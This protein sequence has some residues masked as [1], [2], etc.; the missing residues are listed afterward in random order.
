MAQFIRVAYYV[1]RANYVAF[2]LERSS[3]HRSFRRLHDDTG[4]AVDDGKARPE[5]LAPPC[6]WAFARHSARLT[7]GLSLSAARAQLDVLAHQ[8]AAQFP[9]AFN[10]QYGYTVEP[11][12]QAMTGNIR[13]ALLV[14]L[15][16]VMLVLLIACANVAN[17]LLV[18]AVG[19]KREFTIRSALGAARARIVRQLL[20]E[21]VLL[22]F[23]GALAG[24]VLGAVGVRIPLALYLGHVPFFVGSSSSNIPP[25]ESTRRS[26]PTGGCLRLRC[27]WRLR[28]VFY[29]A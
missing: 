4:Q 2:N 24:L 26:R 5:V 6:V 20:T 8:Y 16:A 28:R 27:Y 23:A 17:L 29:S 15:G 7:R 3:L 10:Q 19:R 25:S 21:S 1:Q 18:R 22:S 14:L 11:L 9:G 13:P 12:Q